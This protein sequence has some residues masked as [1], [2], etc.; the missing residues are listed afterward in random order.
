[1]TNTTYYG[2]ALFLAA[3]L[4]WQFISGQALG[5]WWRARLSRREDRA[6]CWL[7]LAIQAAIFITLLASGRSW[8]VR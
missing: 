5:S 6:G 7:V 1:M 2:M 4:V 8:H 3:V